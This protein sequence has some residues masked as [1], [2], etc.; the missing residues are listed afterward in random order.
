M[1][2]SWG[3]SPIFLDFSLF[4]KK[5]HVLN[6]LFCTKLPQFQKFVVTLYRNSETA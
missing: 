3:I 4:F 2:V 5:N 6:K 1:N